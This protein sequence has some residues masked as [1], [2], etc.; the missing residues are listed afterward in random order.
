LRSKWDA[1]DAVLIPLYY[2]H[3]HA[4]DVTEIIHT[5]IHGFT[6]TTIVIDFQLVR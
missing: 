2:I 1:L 5:K 3:R 6:F 4:P